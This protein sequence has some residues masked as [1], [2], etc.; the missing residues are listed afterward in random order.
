MYFG[1]NSGVLEYDGVNWR[2]IPTPNQSTIR[3][4]AVD[5][6]GTIYVGAMNEF[7]YLAPDSLGELFYVSLISKLD[8]TDRDFS[9]VYE[10][11]T[12]N[13]GIYFRTVYALFRY[14]NGKR[15]I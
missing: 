14:R 13:D 12:T 6:S 8:S 1:N 3:S 9:R 11:I 10:I 2:T 5:S 7:G 4:L 15:H